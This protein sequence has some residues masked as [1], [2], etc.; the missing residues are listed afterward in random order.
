MRGGLSEEDRQGGLVG[1]GFA[2]PAYVD[3][4]AG[5]GVDISCVGGGYA[6]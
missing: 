2:V 4:L 5:S 1:L 6:G 3:G